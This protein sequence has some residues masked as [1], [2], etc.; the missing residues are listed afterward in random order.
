[1]TAPPIKRKAKLNCMNKLRHADEATA[2]IAAMI[3][4]ERHGNVDELYVYRCPE[5]LGWHLTKNEN[6][7]RVTVDELVAEVST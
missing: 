4:I 6:P 3:A 1:M 7:A 5:C 2:R